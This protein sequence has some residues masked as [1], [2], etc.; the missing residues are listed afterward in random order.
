MTTSEAGTYLGV[1]LRTLYK[2]IDDGQVPAYKMGRVIRLRREEVD[3]FIRAARIP[4]GALRHL[5]PRR[6]DD[7]EK[8][9]E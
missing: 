8:V 3:E 5:Y 7:D 4:P 2:L 6:G 9:T 1:T